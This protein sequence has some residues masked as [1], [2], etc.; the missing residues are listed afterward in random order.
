MEI[1]RKFLVK[2]DF[3]P[4]VTE[5]VH[6]VQGYLSTSMNRTVRVRIRDNKG[7]LTIKGKPKGISR[8]E[9]EEEIPLEQAQQMLSLCGRNVIDKTRNLVPVGKHTFEVDVFHGEN[10]GLVMAEIELGS[11]NEEFIRP[12]WLGE[13][14][15][16]DK[17]Y[18]NSQLLRNPFKNRG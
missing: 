5:S 17:R 2:G 16:Y 1:E 8:F 9:W 3:M 7:F 11:E 13:E 4:E 15:S 10:E 14:V 6:I 12:S 18:Y